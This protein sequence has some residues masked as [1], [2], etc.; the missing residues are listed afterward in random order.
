ML[1]SSKSHD[2]RWST[3]SVHCRI[4]STC[5]HSAMLFITCQISG[6]LSYL[7][8][9]Q[10]IHRDVS[11]RNCLVFSD[12]IIKLSDI[13]MGS[14]MYSQYYTTEAYLPIRWIPPEILLVSEN[15][16]ST[17]RPCSSCSFAVELERRSRLFDQVRCLQFRHYTLRNHDDM[18]DDAVR[19]SVRSRDAF[20]AAVGDRSRSNIDRYD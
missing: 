10:L 8:S 11:T 7:E 12:Y 16:L 14:P 17:V 3:S 2:E 18:S 5:S 9:R 20:V 1:D 4:H 15:G 6:A 13:A 19:S